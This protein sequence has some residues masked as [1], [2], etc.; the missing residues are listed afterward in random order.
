MYGRWF[1]SY[2]MMRSHQ[3]TQFRPSLYNA[4][5]HDAGLGQ[6]DLRMFARLALVIAVFSAALAGI[7]WIAS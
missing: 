7:V 6:A 4:G 5:K 3:T 1:S 2:M